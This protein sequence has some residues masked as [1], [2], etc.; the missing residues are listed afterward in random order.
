[1]PVSSRVLRV[2]ALLGLVFVTQ[3][4]LGACSTAPN[5]TPYRETPSGPVGPADIDLLT[6]VRQ[7][8]LWEMP[9][10]NMAMTKSQNARVREIGMT[11]MVDHGRIDAETRRV[12]GVLGV[13]LP[14]VPN[15]DQQGWLGELTNAKTGAEFDPIFA[16]RLRYAHGLVFNAIAQ[17]RAG[18]RNDVVREY[19][20][21]ANQA[22]LRHITLLESTGLV[23]YTRLPEA[24]MGSSGV[25]YDLN[26]R[27]VA[28]GIAAVTA[29]ILVIVFV[30][31]RLRRKNRQIR[32]P[33]PPPLPDESI[34]E[35]GPEERPRPVFAKRS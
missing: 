24:S 17:V 33:K 5:Q 1:M 9:A 14:D 16:N 34:P 31:L 7:A 22:V 4:A 35:F 25:T 3:F 18:T 12:A 23:D 10:G 6:K 30:V 20:S 19:A 32:T 11:L 2:F 15:D 8:G 13:P 21:L 29:E 27:D 26:V 28:L